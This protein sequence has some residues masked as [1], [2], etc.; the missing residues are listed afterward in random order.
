MDG[1]TRSN[2]H[3]RAAGSPIVVRHCA[4]SWFSYRCLC[5][6]LV[7]VSFLEWSSVA[8]RG[9]RPLAILYDVRTIVPNGLLLLA[10]L[11][12]QSLFV[13]DAPACIFP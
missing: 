10:E 9:F 1:C 6:M 3:Q 7:Y 13:Y 5:M 8:C 11:V 4:R 2:N 12:L